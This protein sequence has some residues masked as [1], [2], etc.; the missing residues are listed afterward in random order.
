M[1]R[2]GNLNPQNCEV[3]RLRGPPQPC[4]PFY[5]LHKSRTH[6]PR[7]QIKVDF[8]FPTTT[9]K[10]S[11]EQASFDLAFSGSV[12]HGGQSD[13][14]FLLYRLLL[15]STFSLCLSGVIVGVQS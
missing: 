2:L 14:L 9:N 1:N 15:H 5:Q 4:K 10:R 3:H 13:R 7:D 6:K 11:T 12:A 8:C